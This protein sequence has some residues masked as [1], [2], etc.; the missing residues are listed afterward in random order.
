MSDSTKQ[1]KWTCEYC[2]YKNYEAASK[3]T[4]C[5]GTRPLYLISDIQNEE[6]DIYKMAATMGHNKESSSSGRISCSSASYETDGK[7]SCHACTYLNWPRSLK[8]TQCLTLRKK[9]SPVASG[10]PTPVNKQKIMSPVKINTR[11]KISGGTLNFAP[12]NKESS[13][14]SSPKAAKDANNKSQFNDINKSITNYANNKWICKACTYAN[15]P[16]ANK[17]VIC[18]TAKGRLSPEITS[19]QLSPNSASNQPNNRT[20]SPT[21]CGPAASVISQGMQS[22]SG[23]SIQVEQQQSKSDVAS[24]PS[25]PIKASEDNK[26][27]E[28]RLKQIRKCMR[29]NDWLWLNACVGVVDGEFHGVE[30][31]IASGGDPSRALTQEEVT[32]LNRPSAFEVGYTLIHL[33]IR[34]KREDMLAILL[35]ST[36]AASKALK[37]LPLHC[38]P[39]LASEVRREISSTLRQRKA[40]FPCQF[41]TECV[42]FSMPAGKN[43][44]YV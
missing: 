2:T 26:S 6:Q 16:K 5:K 38:S 39:D 29:E 12:T 23:L 22:P 20:V 18:G 31:Y 13:S 42:T 37:H 24:A 17:C 27:L 9:K 3:C 40:G 33:A 4:L 21:G 34:F 11:E 14:S 36:E 30:G 10:S 28:R 35:S 7:W 32:L 25:P 19:P 1:E 41:L 8:C 43:R 15:W 44:T